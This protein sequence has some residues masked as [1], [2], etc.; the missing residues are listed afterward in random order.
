M[1]FKAQ[2]KQNQLLERISTQHLVVGIDIAQQTH[3]ARA[4]NFRG[5]LLGTPLHFSND[6]TGFG[7]L[8]QWMRGLQE[9]HQL[10]D[11]I[12][13]MEPTGHYWLSL[14]AWLKD[15]KLEVVL[16][17]PHLVKKNKE[18]RDNTPSKSDIKDAFVIADMV[19]NGY[20]TFI[21]ETSEVFMELRVL[22]ANRE[23]IVHRLVSVKNQIHRWVDIVF[24]ELR[25]VYKHLIGPGSLATLRL[26]PTSADL[27]KLT[28]RQVIDGWKTVMKRHSG[29]RRAGE[30]LALAARSVGAKHAERAYKL[31][32]QQL[33]AEYDLAT[34]QLQVIEDEV[35]AAL[36]RIP[37]AEPL[38]AI[39]GM[40]ILSVAGILGEAG[41][42]SGY[43]HGNALLRHAGLN[44]AEASS[45]KWKGQMSISKRGRPRLRHALFMATM[46]LI[47]NDVSFKRQHEV[48]VKMKSMKPMRSVMKLC[49]KLARLLVAMAH[50]GEAYEPDRAHPMKQTA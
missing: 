14:A 44:L 8:L 12:I 19:K 33:L 28:V 38:L 2:T 45:G 9:T 41:D 15:R 47:M 4:V 11:T 7:L 18:N 27:Q 16:V 30:L 43:A 35:A 46:A 24:P 23:T 3:V 40:S 5:I 29:E 20:Y 36:I 1:K 34:E 37:L 32:L 42:L 22:M 49:G 25:L 26:F 17:N 31:H 6:D 50:S 10:N 48:N 13:G 21:K 39:K